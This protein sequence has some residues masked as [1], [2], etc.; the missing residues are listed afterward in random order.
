VAREASEH[1][2]AL[3]KAIP[4]AAVMWVKCYSACLTWQALDSIPST[5]TEKSLVRLDGQ[6]QGPSR[7]P[8]LTVPLAAF[9]SGLG[10]LDKTLVG[11]A[12]C[13]S[14]DLQ[15]PLP[16]F[17]QVLTRVSLSEAPP[18]P[19]GILSQ[20]PTHTP[21][22]INTPNPLLGTSLWM[23]HMDIHVVYVRSTYTTS[24]KRNHV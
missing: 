3:C 21:F 13:F 1:S 2:P 8:S 10:Y 4:W 5:K 6:S 23:S 24:R 12:R 18:P 15:N 17:F 7:N 9:P 22:P 14:P 11:M 16:A 20:P 19:R